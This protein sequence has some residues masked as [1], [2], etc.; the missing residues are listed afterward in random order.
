M[1]DI[2]SGGESNS[3][4]LLEEYAD[5]PQSCSVPPPPT[6]V[7][8]ST[9]PL[10]SHGAPQ[11]PFGVLPA[12]QISSDRVPI[13]TI[14][15]VQTSGPQMRKIPVSKPPVP[16]LNKQPVP[17]PLNTVNVPRPTPLVQSNVNIP[18]ASGASINTRKEENQSIPK[19]HDQSYDPL[20]M[21]P[22]S[23]RAF[24]ASQIAELNKQHEEAQ[25]RL[26][27]LM[28]QQKSKETQNQDEQLESQQSP[29]QQE[30]N[31]QPQG[32]QSVSQQQNIELQQLQQL[33]QRQQ[34]L[35]RNQQQK[36]LASTN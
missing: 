7:T 23:D 8:Y 33:Q 4:N 10:I 36:L 16:T 12:Q 19:S 6:Q 32:N 30:Q 31:Q 5:L 29:Q 27:S 25:K 15:A 17:Q 18:I 20:S 21:V 26:E 14:P 3:S 2:V 1:K 34:Q 13:S 24:L 11:K 22:S 35:Q 9:Q 28:L